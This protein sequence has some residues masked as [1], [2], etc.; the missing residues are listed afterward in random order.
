[1]KV[2]IKDIA[3]AANVAKSTVSKVLNDSPNIS[4][5]T[6]VRIRE[7]MKQMNYIPSSL[8]TGLARQK[9]HNISLIIDL[10]RRNDFLNFFFYNIIGGIESVVGPN[11]YELTISNVGREESREYLTRYVLSQKADGIIIDNSILTNDSAEDLRN[12]GFPYVLIG[13]WSGPKMVPCVDINNRLGATMLTQHLLEQ[14]YRK[15][16]FIGG[17]NNEP[18][19]ES[20]SAGVIDAL[21]LEDVEGNP[22][23]VYPDG[24]TEKAGYHIVSTILE[25]GEIPDALVCMNNFVAFG[26][27]KRLKEKGISVPQEIGIVTF[28]NEPLAPYTTPAL[29]CLH[30]DTFGLGAGAAELLMSQI[31]EESQANQ[32][33]FLQQKWLIPEL[34]VRESS[35]KR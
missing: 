33:K 20:R 24:N 19:F 29:T 15:L 28:D 21:L 4:I 32:D 6:K 23:R 1:M 35:T 5:A 2:T 30:L 16:A 9:C 27:L 13:E 12:L 17:R 31:Q 8:A 34:I 11:N 18:L 22:L 3:K 7:I 10:S 26:A 14:G 25:H